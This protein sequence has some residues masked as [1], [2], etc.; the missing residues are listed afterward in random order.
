M[1]KRKN[2]EIHILNRTG[3]AVLGL[4]LLTLIVISVLALW[5]YFRQPPISVPAPVSV[6]PTA[7]DPM[8]VALDA[9][10]HLPSVLIP[11]NARL[12]LSTRSGEILAF[13]GVNFSATG[14]HGNEISVSPDGKRFVYWRGPYLFLFHDGEEDK[15]NMTAGEGVLGR[16]T[17]SADSGT[18][19][20]IVSGL[21]FYLNRVRLSDSVE[22]SSP[23]QM[24]SFSALDGPTI[25]DPKTGRVLVALNEAPNKT[26]LYTLDLFC[27]I[28]NCMST[29]KQIGTI[30]YNVNW[31]SYQP[32]GNSIAFSEDSG[33]IYQF[34][35]ITI[36][37]P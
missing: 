19:L 18:L 21:D 24:A 13:D 5:N 25:I 28:D 22:T 23:Q 15:F 6:V 35:Y 33:N 29:L 11:D 26:T 7:S 12:M 27:P 31:I 34:Q 32:D 14:L 36:W 20:F 10:A 1:T 37:S 30:A 3:M 16:F 8:A 2:D 9:N 17:W 4:G